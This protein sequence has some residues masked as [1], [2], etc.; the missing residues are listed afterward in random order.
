MCVFSPDF[1]NI[2]E[3]EFTESTE[4]VATAVYARCANALSAE[5]RVAVEVSDD[6]KTGNERIEFYYEVSEASR[7]ERRYDH[8]SYCSGH[9]RCS[10]GR[11]KARR[12]RVRLIPRHT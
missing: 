9:F 12:F 7:E 8:F 6:A 1:D 10:R 3:Q 4:N 11:Q 5:A 2:L